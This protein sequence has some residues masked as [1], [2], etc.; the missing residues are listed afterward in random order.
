MAGNDNDPHTGG[1]LRATFHYPDGERETVANLLLQHLQAGEQV[2]VLQ[3]DPGSGRTHILRHMLARSD[4]GLAIYAV[5]AESDLTVTDLLLGLL[6]HLELPPPHSGAPDRVRAHTVERLTALC[7]S[8][9]PIVLALDDA[10]TLGDDVLA[11]LLAVREQTRSEGASPM[12]LL[13]SGSPELALRLA[14]L[15]GKEADP[16]TLSLQGLD[17]SAARAFLEQALRANGDIEGQLLASLDVDTIVE[18]SGGQPGAILEAARRQLGGARSTR[19]HRTRWQRQL[20]AFPE[21]LLPNVSRRGV[22]LVSVAT[23]MLVG[24]LLAVVLVL[25]DPGE[26]EPEVKETA[27]ITPADDGPPPTDAEPTEALIPHPDLDIPPEDDPDAPA[28]DD[29]SDVAPEQEEDTATE[30]EPEPEPEPE[31][32][33]DLER[34]LADGRTW[35]DEQSADAW[36]IQLVAAHDPETVHAWMDNHADA[37]E[38]HLLQARRDGEDW[39]L[40][41]AGAD[42]DREQARERRD[43]LPEALREG[44]AWVR[45]LQAIDGS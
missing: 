30:P 13:L 28:D 10:D 32:K 21:G 45:E 26:D 3:G 14:K 36:T 9:Q 27:A 25:D 6:D 22:G 19:P 24:S 29:S 39:Y 8:G 16:V 34:A 2:V 12:G 7:R 44:G 38:L 15:R 11:A 41:V 5:H 40:V 20:P 43:A 1:G 35:R 33:S 31:Q 23:V 4:H 17:P 37:A 42:D 18:G